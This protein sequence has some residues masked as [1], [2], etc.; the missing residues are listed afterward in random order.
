MSGGKLDRMSDTVADRRADVRHDRRAVP[1]GGRRV[2]DSGRPW[3]LRRRWW[4]AIVSV[5]YVGWRRVTR[6]GAA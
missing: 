4:L 2:A 5:A 3:Y 1:R 6:R